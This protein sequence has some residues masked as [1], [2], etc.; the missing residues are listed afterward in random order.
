M[1][2]A[3]RCHHCQRLVRPTIHLRDGARVDYFRTWTGQPREEAYEDTRAGHGSVQVLRVDS[4]RQIVTCQDCWL[5]PE[6]Q[7]DLDVAR[8][9]G[10]LRSR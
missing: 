2:Q 10:Y 9:A 5:K 1:V 7:R 4:L 3:S 8:D 6:V